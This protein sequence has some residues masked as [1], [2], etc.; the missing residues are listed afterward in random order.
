M[1]ISGQKK[2][3]WGLGFTGLV[4]EENRE[5]KGKKRAKKLGPEDWPIEV[6]SSPNKT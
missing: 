1:P 4:L 6:K 2:H 5:G 3:K